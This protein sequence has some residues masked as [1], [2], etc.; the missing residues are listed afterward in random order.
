M[1][2]VVVTVVTVAPGGELSVDVTVVGCP[3]EPVVVKIVTVA[4]DDDDG[5]GAVGPPTIE[6]NVIGCP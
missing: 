4:P 6:Y 3:F 5:G 1:V 2:P